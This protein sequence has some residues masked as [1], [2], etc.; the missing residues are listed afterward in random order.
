MQT[1]ENK[2]FKL[3]IFIC[4]LLSAF[5]I[6]FLMIRPLKIVVVAEE[7][8]GDQYSFTYQESEVNPSV[9]NLLKRSSDTH[10]IVVLLTP[11]MKTL[12][13]YKYPEI[14]ASFEKCQNKLPC[15]LLEV[16]KESYLKNA[17]PRKD[18]PESK[19]GA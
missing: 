7:T 16:S 9:E 14:I 18:I 17:K 1:A 8:D 2:I 3:F 15:Q 5:I 10:I 4:A 13:N 12:A 6:Y 19:K 11:T